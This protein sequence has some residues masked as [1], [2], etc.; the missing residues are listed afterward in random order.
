MTNITT[1]KL[2]TETKNRLNK[3]KEHPKESFDEVLRKILFVLNTSRTNP[4]KANSILRNIDKRAK[5]KSIYKTQGET[6]E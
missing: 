6:R 4:E 3:F 1:L 5:R 2:S